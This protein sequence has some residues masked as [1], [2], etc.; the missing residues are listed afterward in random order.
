MKNVTKILSFIF[1]LSILSFKTFSQLKIGD[2]KEDGIIFFVDS[3]GNHGLIAYNKDLKKMN[4]NKANKACQEIGEGWH[5]PTKEELE[6]LYQVKSNIGDFDN[7]YYWSST[8]DNKGN[9]WGINFANGIPQISTTK[10]I[11]VCVRP[12]KA[13]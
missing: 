12:V 2:K 4:W 10:I 1:I 7:F 13:F 5:L 11:S 8:I 9:P 3:S 6:K